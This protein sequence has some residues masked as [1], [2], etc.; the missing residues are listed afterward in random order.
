MRS[1]QLPPSD[2]A[3]YHHRAEPRRQSGSCCDRTPRRFAHFHPQWRAESSWVSVR[4]L[5]RRIF[6]PLSVAV[7]LS[8]SS[9]AVIFRQRTAAGLPRVEL[10]G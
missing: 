2:F 8:P 4:R 9:I 3:S 6:R 10:V 1:Q 7:P 5:I